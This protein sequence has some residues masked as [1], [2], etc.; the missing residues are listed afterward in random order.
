MPTEY[1]DTTLIQAGWFLVKVLLYISIA[2]L[3]FGILTLPLFFLGLGIVRTWFCGMD[4]RGGHSVA[5][6]VLAFGARWGIPLASFAATAFF[7]GYFGLFDIFS[8]GRPETK[9][10]LRARYEDWTR[11]V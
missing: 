2:A 3:I 4:E 9:L 7:A 6:R 5:R 11:S 1:F 8:A 10:S